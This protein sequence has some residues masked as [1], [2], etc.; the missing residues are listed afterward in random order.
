M[1]TRFTHH[2]GAF[3]EPRVAREVVCADPQAWDRVDRHHVG[4]RTQSQV[5][6]G[7][8][9]PALERQQALLLEMLRR[10]AGASVSYAQ[11]QDAGIEFPASVVSE[12]ELAGVS[13][14]RC[15]IHK[16]GARRMTGVRLRPPRELSEM[17]TPPS[18][19]ALPDSRESVARLTR[20]LADRVTKPSWRV[21]A[22]LAGGLAAA[23]LIV[24]LSSGGRG[25]HV[26]VAH[27]QLRAAGS[28]A[29]RSHIRAASQAGAG[30]GGRARPAPRAALTAPSPAL[31]AQL[32]AQGHEMLER[33]RYG[34]AIAVLEQT[35][36]ATGENLE[37]C[38][39]PVNET[40][41]TYAY[42]LY[43]LGRALRLDGNSAAAVPVLQRRL[44]IENQRPT[45]QAQLELALAQRS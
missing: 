32:D 13:V 18:G 14:E 6:H 30:A 24:A 7:A 45:V 12:L 34:E 1:S 37:D 3:S 4:D 42:A 9:P 28:A 10:A 33:G 8:D 17:P 21:A 35:L 36:S 19:F 5:T 29:A 27:R 15:D 41:L 16:R 23:L 2:G 22:L 44:Q 20:A 31:A 25:H 38:L 11:L 40:C 39:Q 26:A 43:D